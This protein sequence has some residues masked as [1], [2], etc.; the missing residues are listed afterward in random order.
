[1][2]S[3]PLGSVLARAIRN[4]GD[5]TSLPVESVSRVERADDG[6]QVN[7]EVIELERVPRVTDVLASY[8][9]DVDPSGNLLAWRR[10]RRYIRKQ[11]ADA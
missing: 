8:E 3:E 10:M 6:W 2:G 4:F 7:F 5:L 1:M 9:V 11:E